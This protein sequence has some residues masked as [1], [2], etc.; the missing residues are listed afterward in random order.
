[1]KCNKCDNEMK[2]LK[3]KPFQRKTWYCTECGYSFR[4]PLFKK[5]I[6]YPI[7]IGIIDEYK[8]P[9][10]FF[11]EYDIRKYVNDVE[12]NFKPLVNSKKI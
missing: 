8:F 11:N 7:Y 4:K 10:I 2:W 5:K 6:E 3:V 1:M 12:L 9:V